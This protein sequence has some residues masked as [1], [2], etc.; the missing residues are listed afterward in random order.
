MGCF[1]H[2]VD[3]DLAVQKIVSATTL[4]FNINSSVPTVNL[5]LRAVDTFFKQTLQ[6]CV[7]YSNYF[8]MLTSRGSLFA[9]FSDFCVD[10]SMGWPDTRWMPLSSSS[11][12]RI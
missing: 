11:V 8:M 9:F 4:W 10:D 7:R 2:N 3:H 1:V 5:N 12:Y 6:S